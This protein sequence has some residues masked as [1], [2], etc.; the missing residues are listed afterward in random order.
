M[1]NCTTLQRQVAAVMDDLA[2]AAV[3]GISQLVEEERVVLRLEV[4]RREQEIEALRRRLHATE[5]ELKTAQR[6]A[7]CL[8]PERI[9]VAVQV[10]CGV[11]KGLHPSF[12]C[13]SHVSS[14]RSQGSAFKNEGTQET[15][16]V[17]PGRGKD[18]ASSVQLDLKNEV[19]DAYLEAGCGYAAGCRF[20]VQPE[21]GAEKQ[22]EAFWSDVPD[23]DSTYSTQNSSQMFPLQ[24]EALPA[25]AGMDE[26]RPDQFTSVPVKEECESVCLSSS[27]NVV[28]PALTHSPTIVGMMAGGTPLPTRTQLHPALTQQTGHSQ[29]SGLAALP[30][31][32]HVIVRPR[33][34]VA[35][36]R[37]AGGAHHRVFACP[38][39]GKSYPRFCQLEA[40][41][42]VHSGVKPYRCVE[43]GKRFT[44]KTR[45]KTHQS[46][47]TGERP[48]GCRLCGKRFNRQ[49]NCLRHERFHRARNPPDGPQLKVS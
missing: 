27:E 20:A 46:V 33:M 29:V 8:L 18:E 7:H 48:F 30:P 43:C 49:D 22:D 2:K 39:C 41:Q 40:H 26:P 35:I 36:H 25:T 23:V 45:L 19:E 16:T 5:T 34:P 38:V 12:K 24:E 14:T 13:Q 4:R 32:R 17:P 42:H 9:S 15:L 44:Q 31:G 10:D 1:S 6:S 37:R 11:R 21:N 47:H 3:A 28:P